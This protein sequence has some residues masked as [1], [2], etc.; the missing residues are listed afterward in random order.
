MRYTLIILAAL[1]LV[2]CER[3]L[4]REARHERRV[5]TVEVFTTK[6]QPV[7]LPYDHDDITVTRWR[8]DVI[9]KTD[10]ATTLKQVGFVGELHGIDTTYE[11][12][13]AYWGRP[14]SYI[15]VTYRYRVT[16]T[17]YDT[18]EVPQ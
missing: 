9:E 15:H 3:G 10:C 17:I 11:P 5:D 2:A 4:E 13:S 14:D 8:L 18:L 12:G 6:L 1:M 7:F 16:D